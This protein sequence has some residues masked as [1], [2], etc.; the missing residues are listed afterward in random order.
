MDGTTRSIEGRKARGDATS[1]FR[2]RA[3]LVDVLLTDVALRT[4]RI[5][6]L[7]PTFSTQLSSRTRPDPP[8]RHVEV[9]GLSQVVVR[10]NYHPLHHHEPS[11]SVSVVDPP[12]R[13]APIEK[14]TVLGW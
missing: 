7:L 11:F 6:A 14:V 13:E 2:S 1:V 5:S 8:R 9:V 12:Q 10:L 4:C 3:D